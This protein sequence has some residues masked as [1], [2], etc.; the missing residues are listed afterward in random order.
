VIVPVTKSQI[1]GV[2]LKVKLGDIDGFA[3]YEAGDLLHHRF[4]R[5]DQ[6][7]HSAMF[8]YEGHVRRMRSHLGDL[9]KNSAGPRK[10]F[11]VAL[12]AGLVPASVRFP[13]PLP[14]A[15]KYLPFIGEQKIRLVGSGEDSDP[16]DGMIQ[17]APG[18]DRPEPSG[19]AVQ[20][21]NLGE[22]RRTAAV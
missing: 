11:L 2:S 16:L 17:A 20:I 1:D 4:A 22:C 9:R 21:Q 15:Q 13:Y 10:K 5:G 3:E 12:P 7:D 14:C 19:F 6:P 8:V 18:I